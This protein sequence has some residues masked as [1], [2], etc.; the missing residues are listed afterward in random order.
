[1]LIERQMT[2]AVRGP[3]PTG[4]VV[5][6]PLHAS[7]HVSHSGPTALLRGSDMKKVF[8]VAMIVVAVIA[9]S[10]AISYKR[11]VVVPVE[12]DLAKYPELFPFQ[13]GRSGFRGIK[14][15]IDTNDY[16]FAFPVSFGDAKSYFSAVDAA[17]TSAGWNLTDAGSTQRV[18]LRRKE[19]SIGPLVGEQVTLHYDSQEHEVI[20]LRQDV[21]EA[22][23][24]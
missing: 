6:Q 17:A 1:M 2:M 13:V 12:A 7:T 20:L 14:F 18:Y 8:I 5:N 9:A 10:I 23:E 16:S 21:A 3:I 4:H 15:D 11:E 19:R 24:P 22:P